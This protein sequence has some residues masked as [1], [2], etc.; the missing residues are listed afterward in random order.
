MSVTP[1]VKNLVRL[2]LLERVSPVLLVR[3]LRPYE[4]YLAARGLSLDGVTHDLAWVGA[5]H[6]VMSV[7][8]ATTPGALVQAFLDVAELASDE[9]HEAALNLAGERQLNLFAGQRGASAEDLAFRLYLEHRDVFTSTQARVQ[10]QEAR[11]FVDFHPEVHRPLLEPG[12]AAKRMMLQDQLSRW[13]EG[14][15]R[16]DYVEVRQSESDEE[17]SFVIIHGQPPRSLSVI[18]SPSRR[19]RMSLL[20][21]KQDTVVF[22]KATGRLSINAQYAAEHDFY[23]AV[24]GRVYFGSDGHFAA[25]AALDCGVLLDDPNGALSVE[26]LPALASVVLREVVLEAVDSPRDKLVWSAPDLGEL[27]LGELVQLMTRDRVVRRAK[28]ALTPVGEAKPKLV[29]L[30]PPNK[31]TYDRRTHDAVVREFLFTRGFLRHPQA[32]APALRAV[33]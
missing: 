3:F 18:T 11:R 17:I 19:D 30:A 7:V 25:G 14:R 26:G 6:H 31:L 29:E 15:N 23:R 16:S 13:F 10:S 5:L 12:S 22:D 28:L 2:S 32:A 33:G 21:D 27:F 1:I 4:G 8:D 24:L 9:G 20:P